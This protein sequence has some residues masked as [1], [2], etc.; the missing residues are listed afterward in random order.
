MVMVPRARLCASGVVTRG[1]EAT[2][3]LQTGMTQTHSR[4]GFY[5]CTERDTVGRPCQCFTGLAAPEGSQQV[6]L[7]HGNSHRGNSESMKRRIRNASAYGTHTE[8]PRSLAHA[9][10][11]SGE[12]IA[13][14]AW[15]FW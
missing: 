8:L 2:L 7:Q 6:R 14:R 11:R 15:D 4:D 12:T 5:S 3:A 10:T 13:R 9:S 1:R